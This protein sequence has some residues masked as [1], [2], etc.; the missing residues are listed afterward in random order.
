MHITCITITRPG[1]LPLLRL[2]IHDFMRQTHT[3]RDLLVLHDGD[4]SFDAAVR[5]L[6]AQAPADPAVR[7]LRVPGQQT[8]GALRNGATELATGDLVCQWDDDDRYHP[9]RLELQLRALQADNADFCFLADQLH[10]FAAAAEMSWDDWSREP[11]PLDFVQGS[12]LGRRALM[13][14]Y[15]ALARGEDTSLCLSI[16]HAG[17]RVTRLRDHGWCYVYVFHGGN[18]WTEQH[19]HAIA[20]AKALSGA[21]LLARMRTLRERLAEYE[22]GFG[23]VALRHRNGSMAL[24]LT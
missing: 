17:H 8:L 2:A 22:P 18:V 20:R 6:V 24:T 11:Y 1:R 15:P 10:W 9:M 5:A 4:D 19:H 7:V 16:L 13:P 3:E 12:L 21:R 14:V 23:P